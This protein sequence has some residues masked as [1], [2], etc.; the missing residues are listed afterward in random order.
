MGGEVTKRYLELSYKLRDLGTSLEALR[1]A[2]APHLGLNRTDLRALDLIV[3][4]EGLTAGQLAERLGVTTGAITAVL[5]R[6]EH[7]GHALRRADAE[8]R[9]RVMVWPTE[10]ARREGDTLFVGLRAEL[11]KIL[12][13]YSEHELTVLEEFL[14]QASRT[15]AERAAELRRD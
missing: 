1:N 15:M 2:A 12:S 5:D 9:R 14:E 3:R 4:A 8:D 6:L 13:S 11:F 10:R 7:S